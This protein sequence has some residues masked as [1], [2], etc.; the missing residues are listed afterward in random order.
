MP[1]RPWEPGDELTSDALNEWAASI[2]EALGLSVD[3]SSGL[4]LDTVG[5]KSV[6]RKISKP[7][8]WL[9]QSPV[10][11]IAAG[12][13][14]TCTFYVLTKTGRTLGTRTA[15]VIN[16]YDDAVGASKK[17]WVTFEGGTYRVVTEA[18][19]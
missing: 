13:S 19:S 7:R 18:C 8:M 17:L 5:G 15:S 2:M 1:I 6:I 10:G 3:G 16:D 4:E 12:S 14:G 11:G 9:V